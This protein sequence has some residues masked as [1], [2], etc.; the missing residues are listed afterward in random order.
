MF[1]FFVEQMFKM[2]YIIKDVSLHILKYLVFFFS[3]KNHVLILGTVPY[4]H[5]YNVDV[6]HMKLDLLKLFEVIYCLSS[7]DV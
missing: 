1:F 4:Q 7:L 5:S 6:C 3:S 2:L